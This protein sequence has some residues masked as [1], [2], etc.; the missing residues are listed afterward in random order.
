VDATIIVPPLIWRLTLAAYLLLLLLQRWTY[1]PSLSL[2]SE[3]R[4][5]HSDSAKL[6][7]FGKD[8]LVLDGCGYVGM[9]HTMTTSYANYAYIIRASDIIP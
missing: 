7:L 2:L 8:A 9:A 3:I 1:P 6:L 4:S 5:S